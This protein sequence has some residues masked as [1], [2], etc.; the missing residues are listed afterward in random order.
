MPNNVP[1]DI[2]SM[3]FMSTEYY[4]NTA[5]TDTKSVVYLYWKFKRPI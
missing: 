4:L 1:N 3:L 5:Y 2:I